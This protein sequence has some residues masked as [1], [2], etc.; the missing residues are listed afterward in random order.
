MNQFRQTT[1]EGFSPLETKTLRPW[2]LFTE[3][4]LQALCS[5]DAI[6]Q[7]SPGSMPVVRPGLCRLHPLLDPTLLDLISDVHELCT[8]G[9]AISSL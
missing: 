9:T 1:N 5:Q 7:P 6:K 2:I 4:L 8:D 3:I